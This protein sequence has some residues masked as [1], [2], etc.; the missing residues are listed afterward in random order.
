MRLAELLRSARES[1]GWSLQEAAD[2]LGMSKQYLHSIETGKV[3]NPGLSMVASFVIVYG[4]RPEAIIAA[5][6]PYEM[7]GR[8]S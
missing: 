5:A 7:R 2:T 1:R 3:T 6:V 4:V 8:T